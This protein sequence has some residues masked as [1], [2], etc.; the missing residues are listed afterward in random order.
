MLD[1]FSSIADF[2]SSIWTFLSSFF[3]G[4]STFTGLLNDSLGIVG[5][6]ILYM[7]FFVGGFG[8]TFLIIRFV[9]TILG[10]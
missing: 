10:R 9:K 8:M 2:F 6:L 7:P 3:S 1:F 4:I 5:S